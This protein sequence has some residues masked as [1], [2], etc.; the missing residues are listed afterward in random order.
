MSLLAM[1]SSL[2]SEAVERQKIVITVGVPGK[3]SVSP[4]SQSSIA[5]KPATFAELPGWAA[6][7]HL[8]AYKAFLTSCPSVIE[9]ANPSKGTRATP[10][11]LAGVCRF[12]LSEAQAGRKM[13]GAS[14][15]SFFEVNFRPKRVEQTTAPGLLTGYYEPLLKA[16]RV[17]TAEYQSPVYRRPAD[18]VNVVAESERGAKSEQLTHMR[19]T[20]GGLTPHLTRAE[21]EQG[22]LKGQGLEL[23][24]LRDPVDIYFLQ[25]QG[26]GRIELPDGTKIRISYDGKNGFPY[27]S[28]GRELIEAGTFT[29]DNMSLKALA[30]WLK[31]D[32]KRAEPVMWKNQSYVF[33]RELKGNEGDGPIGALGTALHTG[34]S[35]AVDTR[36][37]TLGMPIYV[38]A[39]AMTHASAK[40]EGFNRLMIAQDVGSAIKGPERGD[41]FFGS[42][43]RAAKVAGVTK[44]PG[45]FYV[46][47]PAPVIEAQGP[48]EGQTGA[49][50][51]AGRTP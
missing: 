14:A 32:R 33:F 22:G 4:M 31:A 40:G 23:L 44:H 15:R 12:A 21:I 8:A 47:E 6:D 42:G 49:P 46:L 25:V 1:F 50:T 2:P 43:D 10:P 38:S 35:L 29:P 37:H 30:N 45:H 7:D 41:I 34:R 20:G 24:Y 17:A 11:A 51:A 16:A 27:T 3:S 13:T 5:L 39:P 18:L 26:S 19:Q 28:I 48:G 9:R 36:F